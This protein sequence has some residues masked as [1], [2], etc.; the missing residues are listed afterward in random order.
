MTDHQNYLKYN[1]DELEKFIGKA[2]DCLWYI[3]NQLS[4]SQKKKFKQLRDSFTL[5]LDAFVDKAYDHCDL[6]REQ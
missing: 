4:E 1:L 3:Q 2:E 5:S 6:K